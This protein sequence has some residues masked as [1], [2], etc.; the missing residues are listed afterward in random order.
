M[1]HAS[2]L[3]THP[4]GLGQRGPIPRNGISDLKVKRGKGL[5]HIAS[6]A[7]MILDILTVLFF[8]LGFALILWMVGER[9]RDVLHYV[10]KSGRRGDVRDDT[11]DRGAAREIARLGG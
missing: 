11:L 9:R 2:S 10:A 7:G 3:A 6:G 4:E 8:V 1:P 5:K